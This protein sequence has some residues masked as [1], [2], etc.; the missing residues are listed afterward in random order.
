M[1]KSA[2]LKM[3]NVEPKKNKNPKLPFLHNFFLQQKTPIK[4]E[5]DEDDGEAKEILDNLLQAQKELE[6]ANRNFEFV[7]EQELIDFYIYQMKAAQTRYQYLLKK[8][9]EKKI[10]VEPLKRS[11]ETVAE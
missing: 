8:A 5:M 1:N 3:Y 11:K 2:A 6:I 4:M 9:K 10:N 7:Q